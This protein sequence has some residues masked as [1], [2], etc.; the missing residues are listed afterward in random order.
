MHVHTR[1]RFCLLCSN[2]AFRL[3]TATIILTITGVTDNVTPF[4][5]NLRT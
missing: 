4:A 1:Q 5:K 3:H 2:I